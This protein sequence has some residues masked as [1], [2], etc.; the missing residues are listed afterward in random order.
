MHSWTTCL[1]C[2]WY[3]E[4]FGLYE[5]PKSD[6][7][8][9]YPP[10]TTTNGSDA[11]L[12]AHEWSKHGTCMSTLRPQCY[13]DYSRGQELVD[14]FSSAVKI[15]ES[16]PT[17]QFLKNCG[18]TPSL[19]ITY[20]LAEVENC[21]AASADG[22]VPHVGCSTGGSLNEVWYYFH[23]TGTIKDGSVVG[24]NSTFASKCPATGIKYPPKVGSA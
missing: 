9:N 11:D 12:W 10:V 15:S 22:F 4:D 18:I 17:F 23:W 19:N 16:L 20:A 24:T 7:S 21:L 13:N 1:P 5:M 2:G 6:S 3:V 8:Q 14:F